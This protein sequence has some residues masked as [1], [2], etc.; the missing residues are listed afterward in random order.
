MQ[1]IELIASIIDKY[2]DLQRIINAPDPKKEAEY[3][4]QIA[5]A[6]LEA[7]GI[8]TIDLNIGE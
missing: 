7:L 4:M 6:K 5:K 1:D 3:Q 8:V 2:A